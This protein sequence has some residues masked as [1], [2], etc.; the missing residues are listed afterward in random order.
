MAAVTTKTIVDTHISHQPGISSK[1]TWGIWDILNISN[2]ARGK[3]MAAVADS[4]TSSCDRSGTY[5]SGTSQETPMP[6][7]RSKPH[8]QP[9]LPHER[10]VTNEHSTS[11]EIP[12][13]H[14]ATTYMDHLPLYKKN[15]HQLHHSLTGHDNDDASVLLQYLCSS[16]DEYSSQASYDNELLGLIVYDDN[17]VDE[18]IVITSAGNVIIIDD[19][20]KKEKAKGKKTK[21]ISD[22]R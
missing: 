1:V 10:S 14:D 8:D 7:N 21:D 22:E 4:A 12:V 15:Q 18:A 11:P 17:S 20:I 9:S 13:S 19:E 3:I 6:Y 5:D 16:S 2:E